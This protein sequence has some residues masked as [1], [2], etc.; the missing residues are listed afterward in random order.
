MSLQDLTGYYY[1]PDFKGDI[2]EFR[3]WDI[4]LTPQ[5]VMNIKDKKLMNQ[6]PGLRY[7]ASFDNGK[8]ER[9][10][11]DIGD[12]NMTVTGLST[13][14]HLKE[15]SWDL[16]KYSGA[17]INSLTAFNINELSYL[18]STGETTKSISYKP[19][20][21][22]N[23]LSIN[24]YNASFSKID[25]MVIIGKDC[26]SVSLEDGL[27]A[28]YPFNGN[29]DDESG[30]NLNGTVNDALLTT[31]RFGN[32]NSAYSFDG[33][34]DYIR[35]TG[36][37]PITNNFTISFWAYCTNGSGYHNIISDGSS[38]AGGSDF[39]INFM[40]N[41]IG[42]RADKGA[43]LNYEDSSPTELS[44]LD[45]INKWVHVVWVMN[46][47]SSMIYLDNNLIATINEAGSNEGYH[48]E[49]SFI[50]A[51]QVWGSPDNFFQGLL[52]DIRIYN[53]PLTQEEIQDLYQEKENLTVTDIDGNIYNS[54]TIG[55]QVWMAENLKTTKYQNGEAIPNVTDD[56]EWSNLVT[57]AYS[58]YNNDPSNSDTYG[59][60]YNW[61]AVD[62]SRNICP[63]GW[64]VP[65]YSEWTTLENYLGGYLVA[66]GKLKETGTTHW[67]SPN[68]GATNETGFTALPAG[69]RGSNPGDFI[70]LGERAVWWTSKDSVTYWNPQIYYDGSYCMGLWWCSTE[71]WFVCSLPKRFE[72]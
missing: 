37:L 42:I 49:F 19:I 7:Y 52:N 1:T 62:D 55:N 44:D 28:Y 65:N 71:N 21:S 12:A 4:A 27:V 24:T 18:W 22:I 60:L 14:N 11:G 48:D 69:G 13:T 6:V 57:G 17:S 32:S 10:L 61:Y 54:V 36:A 26:G 56:T 53:R 5:E 41:N 50:G 51:R 59:R 2:D 43:P 30:N 72:G 66:G 15:S 3:L 20:D 70:Y 40:N 38:S 46:P 9:T 31:D 29:A 34:D 45:L 64:H 23:N 63:S 47:T 39:L 33:I 68:T 35:I 67:S 58:D 16:D 25:T 8:F